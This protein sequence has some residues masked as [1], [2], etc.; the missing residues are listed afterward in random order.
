MF[1]SVVNEVPSV[2]VYVIVAVFVM[3]DPAGGAASPAAAA[4]ADN[5]TT[6]PMARTV[7][8][9]TPHGIQ[10]RYLIWTLNTTLPVA[11]ATR[12]AIVS[13]NFEEFAAP[14]PGL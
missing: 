6:R 13:V 1:D 11:P 8:A 3:T 10:I 9:Q 4:N 2:S 12:D 5:D 14:G 7:R